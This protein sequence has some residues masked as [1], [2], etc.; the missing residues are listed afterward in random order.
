MDSMAN[1]GNSKYKKK[2]PLKTK[3]F[4]AVKLFLLFQ[5]ILILVLINVLL[6]AFLQLQ[7]SH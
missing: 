3:V 5:I 2:A 7:P 6:T 1:E 4:T